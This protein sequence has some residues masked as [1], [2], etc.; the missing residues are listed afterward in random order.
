MRALKRG[1]T[2]VFLDRSPEKLVSTADRPLSPDRES[3]RRR[4]A[5]RYEKYLSAA[6]VTVNGDGTV[7]ETA[8]KVYET[9]MAR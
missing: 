8:E 7:G 5:E 3:L 1:G 9:V 4:Y 6:D 2:A